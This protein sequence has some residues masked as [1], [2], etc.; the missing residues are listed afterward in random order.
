MTLYRSNLGMVE[1]FRYLT[2]IQTMDF[3]YPFPDWLEDR[4]TVRDNVLQLNTQSGL[5][6]V[7]PGQWV[8][9]DKRDTLQILDPEEFHRT[10]K[11]VR[12]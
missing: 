6:L 11:A 8:V 4:V 10:Y 12:E 9:K 3:K 5:V 1:A 7:Q 2:G